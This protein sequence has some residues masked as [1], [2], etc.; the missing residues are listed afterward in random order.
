M[1]HE[2][3]TSI[4]S[5]PY[6]IGSLLNYTTETSPAFQHESQISSNMLIAIY[7]NF[8]CRYIAGILALIANLMTILAVIK[9]E[10]L[11]TPANLCI[12]SLAVADVLS[13]FV[14]FLFT[15]AQMIDFPQIVATLC[16]IKDLFTMLCSN[17]NLFSVFLI[18]LDRFVYLM[19]PMQ[20]LTNVNN[21][22]VGTGLL[23]TWVGL[24]AVTLLSLL[25]KNRIA[26]RGAQGCTFVNYMHHTIYFIVVVGPVA[27][28]TPFLVLFYT[29][30]AHLARKQQKAIAALVPRVQLGVIRNITTDHG[31]ST[32]KTFC[33]SKQHADIIQHVENR[34]QMF[35]SEQPRDITQ[36]VENREQMYT[37]EQPRGIRIPNSEN[38]QAR[39]PKRNVHASSQYKITKM[40]STVLGVYLCCNI[41][42]YISTT[43]LYLKPSTTLVQITI[44]TTILLK[45]Q[46]FINPFIY[47]WKSAPFRRVFKKML[48]IKTDEMV[49]RH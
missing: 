11:T 32:A 39:S 47:A 29:V 44:W 35:T 16:T 30:I 23:I 48:K 18:T 25:Y 20:Y 45:I 40:M 5:I 42:A 33:V 38:R 21:V 13:G 8:I 22:R 14:P 7:L 24:I 43:M 3:N 26:D 15:V 49:P 41:P 31:H 17:G 4:H 37:S 9:F 27:V 28:V 1:A 34:E 10:Y 2:N 19:Y 36:H 12:V 6:G 46:N